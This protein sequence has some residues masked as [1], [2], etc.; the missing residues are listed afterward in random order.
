MGSP[1]HRGLARS[2]PRQT[3]AI[4]HLAPGIASLTPVQAQRGADPA[5][6]AV[7]RSRCVCQ[8]RWMARPLR[9]DYPGATHH[10]FSRAVARTLVAV[11]SADYERTLELLA[12]AVNRF[13]L[14]CHAW[15]FLPNHVHLLV[16]SQLGNLSSA[17]HWL[18]TCAAQTFNKRHQRVGH[19][20]QGRFGSRVVS[21]DRYLL[22]LGRYLPLNPVRAGLC[23]AAEEW[24]WSSYGATAGLSPCPPFL[25]VSPFSDVLGSPGAYAAWVN[26]GLLATT[27]D[28]RGIP[29]PPARTPIEDLLRNDSAQAI[30][31]A[32]FRHGYSKAA[33]ARYLGVSPNQIARRLR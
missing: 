19:L 3:P 24:E 10:V 18:G 25:D 17:M 28:E 9:L 2:V 16:T 12:R 31:D 7:M 4:A 6:R 8:R 14:K 29:R 5:P 11:D 33:I 23:S 20:Y 1:S 30:A 13:E 15:C 22:E 27:L 26:D 32:H 21:D